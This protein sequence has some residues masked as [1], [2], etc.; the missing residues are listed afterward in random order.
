MFCTV[1][2]AQMTLHGML[3]AANR[4][5]IHFVLATDA[6]WAVDIF[7]PGRYRKYPAPM[8]LLENLMAEHPSR[9]EQ[10]E[11]VVVPFMD[12]LIDDFPVVGY[13]AN[14]PEPALEELVGGWTIEVAFD[15]VVT[16]LYRRGDPNKVIRFD[17]ASKSST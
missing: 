3:N 16:E 15:N 11:Q 17:F 13:P 10:Y 4:N 12:R 1:R 2:N 8:A 7:A 6:I 9:Q 14:A 5:R